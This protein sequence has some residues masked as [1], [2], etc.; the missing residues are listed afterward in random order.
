MGDV[1]FGSH[2][3]GSD[4]SSSGNTHIH[5]HEFIYSEADLVLKNH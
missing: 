3:G 5:A 1:A 4:E 2:P